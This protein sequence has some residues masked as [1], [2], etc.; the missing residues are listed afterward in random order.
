MTITLR[1]YQSE[2]LQ[3]VI[4][5]FNG[6][7]RTAVMQLGTGG[8]KTATASALLARAESKG[9]PSLFLAHLDSLI[10]DTHAR[11]KAAEVRAGFVQAG[12]AEDKDALVQVG[13]LATL[14][15]RGV[16]PPAGLVIVDECHRTMAEG[17]R[18]ILDAYPEAWILGLTATPQR[19]DGKALGNVYQ[20]LFSGPSNQWLTDAG[21]LVPCDVIGP[22]EYLERTISDDP[23]DAYERHAR[24]TKAICFTSTVEDARG[25]ALKFAAR[26]W[27]AGII[28]GETPREE[29]EALCALFVKGEIQVLVGVGV[30]IEGFDLPCIETVIM[31]RAFTVTGS[32]LQA[33]GRGL[34]PWPGKTR[35]LVLDLCGSVW[36]HGLPNEQRE[37]SIEGAAVRRVEAPIALRRCTECLAIFQT[38]VECPRCGARGK[39]VERVKR[40]VSRAEANEKINLLSPIERDTKFLA[41]LKNVALYRIRL[42]DPAA[43]EWALRAFVKQFGRQPVEGSYERERA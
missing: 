7:V 26:G 9:I 11:L 18:Q 40:K 23:V 21:F 4:D 31:A 12:R 35:C 29:R 19:A 43:S 27:H 33:I 15:V 2:L 10:S 42:R 41:R 3:Q 25:L 36:L 20:R 39:K 14:R 34:R 32:Y 37:W 6:G 8:G 38:A 17:I 28:I 13:S 30:F 24:G 1:P 5:A 22:K 16:R